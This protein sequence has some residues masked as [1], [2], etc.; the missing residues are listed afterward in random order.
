MSE[1]ENELQSCVI[2][3]PR[4]TRVKPTHDTAFITT[5]EVQTEGV[6]A[7]VRTQTNRHLLAYCH[8]AA[9]VK[10]QREQN[11]GKIHGLRGH[12]K[13]WTEWPLPTCSRCGT[14]W[15]WAGEGEGVKGIFE[16]SE[17]GEQGEPKEEGV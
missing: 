16:P 2:I 13:G 5:V 17:A 12:G 6:L 1:H 7:P 9:C 8:N 11:N 15:T 10:D 4:G 14:Q 3:V